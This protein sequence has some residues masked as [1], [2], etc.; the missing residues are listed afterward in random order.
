ML[1]VAVGAFASALLSTLPISAHATESIGVTMPI[2]HSAFLQ[3]FTPDAIAAEIDLFSH[4]PFGH[5]ES[6]AAA[7]AYAG[8]IPSVPEPATWGLMFVGLIAVG[9]KLRSRYWT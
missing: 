6:R 3:Q 4:D 1:K 9:L 2:D 7:P 5:D 8:T